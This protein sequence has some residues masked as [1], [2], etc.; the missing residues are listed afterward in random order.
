LKFGACT[1][2]FGAAIIYVGGEKIICLFYLIEKKV[3]LT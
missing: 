3:K 2:V 1:I